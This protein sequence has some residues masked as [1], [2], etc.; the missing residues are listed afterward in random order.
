MG[1][2]KNFLGLCFKGGIL[3]I[4]P[5]LLFYLLADKLFEV[6]VALATPLAPLF[7]DLIVDFEDYPAVLAFLILIIASFLLG[8]ALRSK[9]FQRFF[10]FV[11][12]KT[13]AYIPLYKA[14]KRLFG[15]LL[16]NSGKDSYQTGLI[17]LSSGALQFVYIIEESGPYT[18]VLEPTAPSGFTGFVRAYPTQQVTVLKDVSVGDISKVLAHWG[19]GS[20][21]I[22]NNVS[23]V[24]K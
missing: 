17:E 5:L 4:F 2:I 15:G 3:V 7:P 16:G 10:H 22:L 19:Y 21:S 1:S 13:I 18:V 20:S 9:L 11:E 6:F 8:L 14:I 12:A 24:K 23:H